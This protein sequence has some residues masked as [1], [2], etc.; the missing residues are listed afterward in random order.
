M[1]DAL[2]TAAGDHPRSRGVYENDHHRHPPDWG[3]SPLARGLREPAWADLPDPGIIPARAGFTRAGPDPGDRPEDHPRSRGV[4]TWTGAPRRRSPR[5][6]PA[7]AGFTGVQRAPAHSPADHP[8]SR[9]VYTASHAHPVG[10]SGSSPLARGL[11]T[12]ASVIGVA[13]R[14]I[15][16]RAGFTPDPARGS[17]G[18]GDH[19]RSRGVYRTTTRRSPTGSGSSPLA[20]G[21][22]VHA[23]A[24]PAEEGIIPARA[25]FTGVQARRGR[26]PE[27]HPRSRGVYSPSR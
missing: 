22:L 24:A 3:S 5:I 15:P 1:A 25:G 26:G 2:A 11:L 21:L 18:V 19:P 7:R 8:R 12:L 14:I 4:Y 20:R 13:Y 16:A 10:A 9:G 23:G 17:G 6:I 27:D